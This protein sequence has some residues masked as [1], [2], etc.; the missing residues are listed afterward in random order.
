MY[1]FAKEAGFKSPREFE[2]RRLRIRKSTV[3]SVIFLCG[4]ERA[5]CFAR[6]RDS[7]DFSIRALRGGKILG[8]VIAESRRGY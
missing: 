6:V 1:L 7:K 8:Y 3:N 4:D 5:N 2:S